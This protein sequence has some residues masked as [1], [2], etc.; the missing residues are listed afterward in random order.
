MRA[1]VLTKTALILGMG[2]EP[3]EIRQA[4]AD[5]REAAADILTLGQ[6]LRPS[7]QH[8]PVVRWVTPAE[9][10]EWKRIGEQ[11]LG[12]RHVESGP[13]VRSS[14]HAKDQA[15]EVEA[16]GPGRIREVMEADLR[17]PAQVAAAWPPPSLVQIGAGAAGAPR[18]GSLIWP[19][20][21]RT[22]RGARGGA[23]RARSAGATR[24]TGL[25]RRSSSS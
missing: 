12:F 5:L 21:D 25:R 3:E 4:M 18:R 8:I 14:Y 19:R 1:D 13:L 2:E 17:A 15:R 11:E 7:L 9:F 22:S 24:S 20:R 16:G 10:A 23:A 6:Y